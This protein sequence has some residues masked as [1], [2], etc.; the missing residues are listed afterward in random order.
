MKSAEQLNFEARFSLLMPSSHRL[1]NL[2]LEYYHMSVLQH[3]GGSACSDY[4]HPEVILGDSSC[5]L[6]SKDCVT[7][8]TMSEKGSMSIRTNYGRSTRL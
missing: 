2:L 8:H 1:S 5:P 4:I 7:M 3:C 6:H